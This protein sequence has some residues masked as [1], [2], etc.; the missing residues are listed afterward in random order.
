MTSFVLFL[1]GVGLIFASLNIPLGIVVL[2]CAIEVSS[3][4][5]QISRLKAEID[6][7][8]SKK[9]FQGEKNDTKR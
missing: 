6:D 5:S 9:P 7:L 8:R 1:V 2:L 4:N 3:K